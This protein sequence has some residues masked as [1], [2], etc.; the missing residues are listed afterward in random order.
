M[1]RQHSSDDG[2]RGTGE[3]LDPARVDVTDVVRVLRLLLTAVEMSGEDGLRLT[4]DAPLVGLA[5]TL[6][7][8]TG[9]YHHSSRTALMA[10]R[11]L[12]WRVDSAK[13][14]LEQRMDAEGRAELAA[15]LATDDI[16]MFLRQEP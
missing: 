14:L 13:A 10:L 11:D 4:N 9:A 8:G 7:G 15:L 6:V 1:P 2:P 12:V 16:H 3:P 5:R